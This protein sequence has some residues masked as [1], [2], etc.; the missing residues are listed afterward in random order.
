MATKKKAKKKA[1]KKAAA[2]QKV[3]KRGSKLKRSSG[4]KMKII[5]GIAATGTPITVG[6]DG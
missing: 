5:E 3:G 6:G 2:K 1:G 4:K